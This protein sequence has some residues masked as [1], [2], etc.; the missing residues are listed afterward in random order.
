MD[1]DEVNACSP[2]R[3]NLKGFNLKCI[4]PYDL[5]LE[6][7]KNAMQDFLDYPG[8]INQQAI[9]KG[10]LR[11]ETLLTPADFSSMVGEYMNITLPMYCPTL[12]KIQYPNGHHDLIPANFF[13]NNAIQYSTEGLEI[14]ASRHSSGWQD[15]ML[16]PFGLWF[17]FL[18]AIPPI[19]G[20]KR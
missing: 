12:V 16:N 15:I 20:S 1:N 8:F 17:L 11:L 19:T 5:K 18:I 7:L 6:L 3:L 14:K 4:L 13:K 9:S 10:M 2:L